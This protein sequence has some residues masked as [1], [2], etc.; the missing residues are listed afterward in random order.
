MERAEE[1]VELSRDE[2]DSEGGEEAE[3]DTKKK[4]GKKKQAT[5]KR[6]VTITDN[7]DDVLDFIQ[8][9]AVKSPRVTAAPLSLRAEN[10]ARV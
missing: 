4:T 7:C 3:E 9:V 10:F 6:L 2:G 5:A 8:A 1:G